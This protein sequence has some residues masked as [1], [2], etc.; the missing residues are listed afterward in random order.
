MIIRALEGLFAATHESHRINRLRGRRTPLRTSVEALEERYMLSHCV[1]P[2]GDPPDQA[3]ID[4]Y[5]AC[6]AEETSAAAPEPPQPQPN[7]QYNWL[8]NLVFGAEPAEQQ[9]EVMAELGTI[10]PEVTDIPAEDSIGLPSGGVHI[11]V[12]VEDLADGEFAGAEG[13]EGCIGVIVYDG[14]NIYVFHFNTQDDPTDTLDQ[15]LDGVGDGAHAAIFGG[16]GTWPSEQTL[17]DVMDYFDDHPEITIDGYADYPGL[18]VDNEG[19]Y[20]IT[21]VIASLPDPEE[22]PPPPPPP[23]KYM[24]FAGGTPVLTPSGCKQI[25]SIRVGDIILAYDLTGQH[26]VT[27]RVL[28]LEEHEGEIELL[29]LELG[30]NEVVNVTKGHP[31]LCGA[32]WVRS[33]DLQTT[34]TVMDSRGRFV[35]IRLTG[36]QRHETVKVYNIRTQAGTYL[37]GEFGAVV[38]ARSLKDSPTYRRQKTNSRLAE[39]IV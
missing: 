20:H 10:E 6:I 17:E 39:S 8:E 7:I 12:P 14:E 38:S 16:D 13:M 34:G 35:D 9:Q 33:E 29:E 22:P 36:C 15:V 31:F 30:S 37:I 18:Y 26:P 2:E 25:E 21:P 23:L 11:V 28:E 1:L 27:T 24:C 19:G 32:V 5:E 3:A 4:A